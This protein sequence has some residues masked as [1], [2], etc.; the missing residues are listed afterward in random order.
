MEILLT[1]VVVLALGFVGAPLWG[2]TAAVA[3]L[4]LLFGAP[5]WAWIIFFL[6]LALFNIQPLR[7]KL[8]TAHIFNFMKAKGF[9]PKI[10]ETERIAISAGNTWADGELFSG[11]PNFEKLMDE[12]ISTLTE[13]EQ[14]FLDG[15]TEELCAMVTDWEIQKQRDLPPDVWQFIKDNKFWGLI[16]PKEYDG[17][18]FSPTGHSEIVAKINSRSATLA[19]SVIVPNSLGPAELLMHYG[20]EEQKSHYLPRL[21]NGKEI[22]CFALTEPNAG[23]DA[24][25]MTSHGVVFK[26]ENGELYMRLNFKKRYITLAAISTVLGLAF[27]LR[28][29]DNL[30]GKGEDV[31]ITCALIPTNTEGVVLGRRHDPMGVPFYNCPVEGYDVV[32]PVS[33]I[34]GG[35]E[36]AGNGWR[37]L[38]ESLAVGRGISLPAGA[39]GGAKGGLRGIGAYAKIRQQFGLAIGKFEGIEEPLARIGGF[40]YIIDAMR[41]Y[42][43]SALDRGEKPAVLTAIAKYHAT[44]LAR[45]IGTDGCDIMGGAAISRGPRNLIAGFPQ[46]AQIAIT[47]EGANILT[48]TLMIFGQ[49]AIRCHPYALA[50]IN[51]VAENDLDAFDKAFWGHTGHMIRNGVRAFLLSLSR[52]YL[53]KS[54]V[55]G[56]I[57]QYFR[58]LSWASASFAITADLAMALQGGNLKRMEK[59]TGRFADILSWMYLGTSTLR[60]FIEDGRKKE[61]LPLVHWSMQY[62][63]ANIQQAFDGIY[64]NFGV[65]GF[66]ALGWWSRMNPISSMPSDKLGGQVARIIQTPGAQRDALTA[67]MF[68]SQDKEDALGRLE[69][70][71]VL[72]YEAE[73]IYRKINTAIKEGK[74]EKAP[75]RQLVENAVSAEVISQEDMQKLVAAETA[76]EDAIQVD[77]FTLEEYKR[78]FVD[79]PAASRTKK[80]TRKKEELVLA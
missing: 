60:R 76:R 74:L 32:L 62:A 69:H 18:G 58:K 29:P 56:E 2:W 46:A 79:A 42:T 16:I 26:G 6:P 45:K 54:P 25:S 36:H 17:L 53:A 15:P 55:D 39:T 75:R 33:A 43:C 8:V 59:L 41:K 72:V 65:P 64:A 50:E 7:S 3:G 9:L 28:D 4:M 20:T 24:G 22:P 5:I 40:T 48:R 63:L 21:A 67:G 1:L 27:K 12:P 77:S 23:S 57:A 31:G 70:A 34:I 49:G 30:L 78:N 61:D 38:M 52:G 68:V 73:G 47:V 66:R 13:E 11:K 37:M 44:E 14:A 51:S 35:P 19:N 10:S 80:P 71:L